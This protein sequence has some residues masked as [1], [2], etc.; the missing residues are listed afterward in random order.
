MAHSRFGRRFARYDDDVIAWY[1]RR[2]RADLDRMQETLALSPFLA[3]AAP[4]I[5]DTACCGYLYW[6]DQAEIDIAGWPAVRDWLDR[7]AGLPGW[8]SP[9]AMFSGHTVRY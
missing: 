1:D 8:R 2:A 6:A 4:S 9:E 3:G 7:I 5:A